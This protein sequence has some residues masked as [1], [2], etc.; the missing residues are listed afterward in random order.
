MLYWEKNVN[1]YGDGYIE[2]KLGEYIFKISPMSFYQ[3][4]PVQAEVL[5]NIAIEAANLSKKEKK[6]IELPK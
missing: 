3:V 1:L 2:D 4:N 5:Y 6:K